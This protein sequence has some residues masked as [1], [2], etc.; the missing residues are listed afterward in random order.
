MA[1]AA[2]HGIGFGQYSVHFA[3]HSGVS[4]SGSTETKTALVCG[5]AS[6]TPKISPMVAG[7]TSGQWV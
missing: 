7:Q 6:K 3:S 4:R 2:G 1:R 5:E